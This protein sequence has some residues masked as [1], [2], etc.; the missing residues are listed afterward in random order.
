MLTDE[1]KIEYSLD[2]EKPIFRD[3]HAKLLVKLSNNTTAIVI[4]D[5]IF[6][7]NDNSEQYELCYFEDSSKFTILINGCEYKNTDINLEIIDVIDFI[8]VSV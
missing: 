7:Y 3:R 1:E 8:N 5:I 2:R 4:T 6:T